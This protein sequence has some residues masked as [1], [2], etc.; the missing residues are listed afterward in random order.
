MVHPLPIDFRG[1]ALGALLLSA[2]L[3]GSSCVSYQ[4]APLD[5]ESTVTGLRSLVLPP[6]DEADRAGGYQPL[7]LVRFALSHHPSLAVARAELGVSLSLADEAAQWGDIDVGWGAMDA[8][9]SEWSA[10]HTNTENFVSGLDVMVELPRIGQRGAERASAK[11]LRRRALEALALEEWKLDRA[12]WLACADV[13][14]GQAKLAQVQTGLE[15][16]AGSRAYFGRALAAGAAT[17]TEAGLANGDWLDASADLLA[18]EAELAAS[19]RTLNGLLGLPAS[20]KL[21]LAAPATWGLG[22]P[23]TDRETLEREALA[24]R[25]E[26]REAAVAYESAEADLR[27]AIS[28]QY[29]RVAI[30]TGVSLG[31]GLLHDFHGRQIDTATKRRAL[32]AVRHEAA[33][34]RVLGEVQ[35]T[36]ADYTAESAMHEFLASQLV[37]AAEQSLDQANLALESGQVTPLEVLNVQRGLIDAQARLGQSR[38]DLLRM[39]IR[40]SKVTGQSLT[41]GTEIVQGAN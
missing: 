10:G 7:D 24:R 14:M 29:P 38:A 11:A 17:A 34:A 37:P 12:V 13:T 4:A 27:L 19:R 28:M 15:V 18:Q 36:L 9:S 39:T 3:I 20:Y 8:L 25:P 2:S 26:V 6:V 23:N 5:L 30:G 21:E 1:R 41:T 22:V 31:L 16:T 32:A 33:V 35:N 40:L